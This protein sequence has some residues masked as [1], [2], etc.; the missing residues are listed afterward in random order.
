MRPIMLKKYQLWLLI[1]THTGNKKG[2][3]LLIIDHWP[4][5]SGTINIYNRHRRCQQGDDVQTSAFRSGGFFAHL[6]ATQTKIYF[7]LQQPIEMCVGKAKL[8]PTTHWTESQMNLN[9]SI[10][11]VCMVFIF[12]PHPTHPR[13]R[14]VIKYLLS[15][16]NVD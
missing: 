9:N 2:N 3:Y 1:S 11:V 4:T 5:G 13:T 7:D 10:I 12:M 8:Q 14:T 15:R 16:K 6:H